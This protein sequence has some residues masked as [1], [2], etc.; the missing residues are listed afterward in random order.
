MVS[1][2]LQTMW[3]EP[4]VPPPAAIPSWDLALA[5]VLVPAS[6]VEGF[7][8]SDVPWPTYS[9]ALAMMCAVTL[10]WR[11]RYPLAMVIVGFGAQ[12]LA[13]VGPSLAGRDYG[14]LNTTA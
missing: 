8:R 4:R 2:A 3:D 9:I 6:L 13:G 11:T 14:V 10:V 7:L 12:T 5:G 1:S